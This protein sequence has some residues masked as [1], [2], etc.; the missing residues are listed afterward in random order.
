[1]TNSLVRGFERIG[2]WLYLGIAAL[3][4]VVLNVVVLSHSGLLE[5]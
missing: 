4:F 5:H 3:F 1:M 2:R